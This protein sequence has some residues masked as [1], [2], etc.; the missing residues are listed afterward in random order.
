MV[1]L[2]PSAPEIALNRAFR[3]ILVALQKDRPGRLAALRISVAE[4]H[5]CA[6]FTAARLTERHRN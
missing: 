5:S 1:E 6:P 2:V 3:D 4:G